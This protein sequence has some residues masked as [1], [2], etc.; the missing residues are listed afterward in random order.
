MMTSYTISM[1]LGVFLMLETLT[2][3]ESVGGGGGGI[4][5]YVK[6]TSIL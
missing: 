2:Y 5:V 3:P 6:M 1:S 4:T